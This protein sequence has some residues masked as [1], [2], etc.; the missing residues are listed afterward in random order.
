MNQDQAIANQIALIETS[1]K[2]PDRTR[3][4]IALTNKLEDAIE[5]PNQAWERRKRAN[6][7]TSA[8]PCRQI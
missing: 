1:K 2:L 7:S 8:W 6:G 4:E 5:E 3:L